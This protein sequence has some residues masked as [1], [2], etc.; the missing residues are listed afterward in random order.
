MVTC[1]AKNLSVKISYGSC[2]TL[3]PDRFIRFVVGV[4]FSRIDLV[5]L[6]ITVWA[7]GS[8]VLFLHGFKQPVQRIRSNSRSQ[9][10]GAMGIILVFSFVCLADSISGQWLMD[11][12]VFLSSCFPAL[13]PSVLICSYIGVSQLCFA[14]SSSRKSRYWPAGCS[15]ARPRALTWP[16][17]LLSSCWCW[18]PFTTQNA[19]VFYAYI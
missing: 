14:S 11:T 5:H 13:H 19:D 1:T 7:S 2:S 3:H 12:S 9:E 4:T 8:M 16:P 6:G 18:A 10:A 17:Q 15:I